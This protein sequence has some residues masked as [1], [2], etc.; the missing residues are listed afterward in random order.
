MAISVF[1]TL[2]LFH[3]MAAMSPGPSFVVTVRTAAAEGFRV[4]G[5]IA[6]GLGVG[7]L[8]WA[9][10]AL[11]GLAALLEIAPIL[12]IALKVAGG[13]FLLWI[14]LQTWRHA[15][16]PL[17]EPT[18]SEG[19][20]PR[21]AGAAFRLGLLTQLSN[22]KVVLFFG[23]V[24]VGLIPPG[25]TISAL[26]LLLVF[27]FCVETAWYLVVARVFSTMGFRRAYGRVKR[28]VDRAFG[29]LIGI[30]AAKITLS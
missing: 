8:A 13:V 10:A 24:F 17:P 14:A 12:L 4:G 29:G 16:T 21:S 11:L 20:T 27:V 18:K 28:W 6:L 26:A 5:F 1:L 23:A 2:L 30:F 25:T 7:A 3:A 19:P 22:P 15:A 9:S